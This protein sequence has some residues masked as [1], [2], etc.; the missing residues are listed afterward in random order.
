VEDAVKMVRAV[1]CSTAVPIHGSKEEAAGFRE[2]LRRE[3]P[4]VQ[5]IV[6]EVLKVYKV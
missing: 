5:V 2:R 3:A 1:G 4:D 6:P